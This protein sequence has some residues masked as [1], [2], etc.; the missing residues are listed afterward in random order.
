MSENDAG[1]ANRAL[2]RAAPAG[3]DQQAN[4]QMMGRVVGPVDQMKP[5][6]YPRRREPRVSQRLTGSQDARLQAGG[7]R[8]N[9][10][11]RHPTER[12]SR[13][14]LTRE[15][16]N[17]SRRV[18]ERFGGATTE[19][20]RSPHT[21]SLATARR[22]ARRDRRSPGRCQHGEQGHDGQCRATA[23]ST[24]DAHTMPHARKKDG[25]CVPE[26]NHT[27]RPDPV[28]RHSQLEGFSQTACMAA[29]A[30][31]DSSFDQRVQL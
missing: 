7:R 11:A 25:S 22:N 4:G 8:A 6:T 21:A 29:S 15:R 5:T 9:V 1:V 2:R 23:I 30:G 24:R 16:R 13:P 17:A 28:K 20:T 31:G 14:A 12:S 26:R 10:P 3:S 19:R 27:V 18:T